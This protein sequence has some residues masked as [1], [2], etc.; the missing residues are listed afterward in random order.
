[1]A[2][3]DLERII[4]AGRVLDDETTLQAMA[5]GKG[6]FLLFPFIN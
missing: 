1:M 6:C 5:S 4:K 3:E 2:L